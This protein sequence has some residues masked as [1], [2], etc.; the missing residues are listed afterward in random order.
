M[1]ASETGELVGIVDFGRTTMAT[2]DAELDTLFRF[3]RTP[4]LFVP[5]EWESRYRSEQ[6]FSLLNG[7]IADC[8]TGLTAEATAL[9][10][11]MYD[12]TY[13]LWKIASWGW[14]DAQERLLLAAL[15]TD[16]YQRLV[17]A[18]S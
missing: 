12:L 4:W 14:S 3:W 11:S 17:E 16:A 5:E 1:I 9:R 8:T 2:P 7:I 15:D 13:R 6:D 10:L 18:R